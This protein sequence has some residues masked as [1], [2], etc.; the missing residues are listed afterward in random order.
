[1]PS[2]VSLPLEVH[3][4]YVKATPV[5]FQQHVDAIAL[6]FPFQSYCLMLTGRERLAGAPFRL[7]VL[8]LQH[9]HRIARLQPVGDAA[10]SAIQGE[11]ARFSVLLVDTEGNSLAPSA[12]AGNYSLRCLVGDEISDAKCSAQVKPDLFRTTHLCRLAFCLAISLT[13][14]LTHYFVQI[15]LTL[16]LIRS[17]T[18]SLALSLALSETI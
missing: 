8:P 4:S 18:I 7:E 16:F 13:Y 6:S 5:N 12:V 17:L 10:R 3:S 11:R 9:G 2:L 14:H 15:S 1:M